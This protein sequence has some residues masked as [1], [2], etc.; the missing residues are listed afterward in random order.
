M[1]LYHGTNLGSAQCIVERGIEL[2]RC[3]ESTDFGQGFYTTEEM[4]FAAKWARRKAKRADDAPALVRFEVNPTKF[5]GIK[6]F[7]D[8]TIEWCQFIVNNRC[9]YD[10]YR[11]TSA[12]IHNIDGKYEIIRGLI[13]D[14]NIVDFSQY[15]LETLH[16]VEE[17]DIAE[18]YSKSYPEQYTFHSERSFT[19]LGSPELILMEG[20][21]MQ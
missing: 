21:E 17:S 13:A 9:G 3:N 2:C 14:G 19:L 15:C 10:Y 12:G 4:T 11:A 6:Y 7:P 16:V 1:Y 18:V 5:R 8:P 20:G